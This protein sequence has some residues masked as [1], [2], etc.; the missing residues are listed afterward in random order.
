MRRPEMEGV[1]Q[2]LHRT[3]GDEVEFKKRPFGVYRY[4]PGI[5]GQPPSL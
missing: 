1:A 2:T 4:V 3:R 5:G